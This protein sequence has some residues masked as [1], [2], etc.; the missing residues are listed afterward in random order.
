VGPLQ[1]LSCEPSTSAATPGMVCSPRPG[2]VSPFLG[3]RGARRAEATAARPH[4]Q[5]FRGP[6]KWPR[7]RNSRLSVHSS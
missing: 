7:G 2:F 5:V 1:R 4:S 6:V 3:P